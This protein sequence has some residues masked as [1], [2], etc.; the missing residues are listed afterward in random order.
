MTARPTV[1]VVEDNQ[2]VRE[3]ITEF[4]SAYGF[5]IISTIDGKEGLD[6]FNT[7]NPDFVLADVLLPRING[8]Q[9]CQTIKTGSRPVPVIL[10]SALY[11]SS[12]LQQEGKEKYGADDYLIKPLDLMDLAHRICRL[13]GIERPKPL[14]ELPPK[15]VMTE[16]D[17][18]PEVGSAVADEGEL[19]STP[20]E[21]VVGW[22]FQRKSTGRLAI[23]AYGVVRTVYLKEGVPIFVQ[24]TIREEGFAHLLLNDGKLNVEQ[25]ADA[26]LKAR[27]T[28]TMLGKVLV[29]NDAISKAD[30]AQYLI[31][32]VDTRLLHTLQLPAGKYT[33]T[34]DNS[35]LDKI[36]R[37]ELEIFD[38]VYQAVCL[39]TS[40]E[41]L[42]ERFAP[43][44]NRKVVKNEE[45]LAYAGRIKWEQEHLD[46]FIFI[47]GERTVAQLI[48]EAGQTPEVIRQ[49][50]YTLE[51]FGIVRFH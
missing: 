38:Q 37:P 16:T 30:L 13:L 15:L 2:D 17:G 14:D 42:R 9:L 26:E 22:L 23:D 35:F 3:I 33:F 12:N 18:Q 27:T 25:L 4:L 29:E 44:A 47:D 34:E 51:V 1:L 49:L 6:L 36:R 5:T 7:K 19:E 21:Q 31:E 50:L 20:I 40:D 32:E 24:S 39:Y 11:K 45:L 41:R 48:D 10:M 43:R 28:K 46:A 8:F